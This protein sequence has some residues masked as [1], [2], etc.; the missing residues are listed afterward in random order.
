[1]DILPA[2]IVNTGSE[3]I[4]NKCEIKGNKSHLTVG[5]L[6]MDSEKLVKGY[7]YN[8]F[9]IIFVEKGLINFHF[10]RYNEQKW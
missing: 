2:L 10:N 8:D 6:K 7:V 1:M 9:N 3:A 5:K 4:V